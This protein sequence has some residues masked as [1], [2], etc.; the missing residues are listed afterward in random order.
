MVVKRNLRKPR[1]QRGGGD[2]S[3]VNGRV[4]PRYHRSGAVACLLSSL[5]EDW[6]IIVGFCCYCFKWGDEYDYQW[7]KSKGWSSGAL[8]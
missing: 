4:F 3:N 6:L 7:F 1:K 5:Q 2:A 8:L